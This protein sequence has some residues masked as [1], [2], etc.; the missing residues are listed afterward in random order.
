MIS[1]ALV[2]ANTSK[3]KTLT[4]GDPG[5]LAA[6]PGSQ[7][8]AIA[9]RLQIQSLLKDNASSVKHLRTWLEGIEEHSGYR[10]LKD[11]NGKAFSSYADFCKAKQ[12]WGL[13]YPPKVIDQILKELESIQ[14]KIVEVQE[15]QC[16]SWGDL[17][18]YLQ[19]FSKVIHDCIDNKCISI[20]QISQILN[21]HIKNAYKWRKR[22]L[23]LGWIES[24]PGKK[25]GIYQITD[26]GRKQVKQ[27]LEEASSNGANEPL[28]LTIPHSNPKK[29]AEKLISSLK[30]EQLKEIHELITKSLEKQ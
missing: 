27:W 12:P 3:V 19:R 26:E 6:P 20:N 17:E 2:K 29:A 9:V 7:P 30:A 11:E 23:D 8:W 21:I 5:D 28:W 1:R 16:R 25:R 15:E 4:L 24:V 18:Q 22:W 10:Q 13:G 14:E